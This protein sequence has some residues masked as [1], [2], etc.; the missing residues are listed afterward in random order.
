MCGRPA[1]LGSQFPSGEETEHIGSPGNKCHRLQVAVG[2]PFSWGPRVGADTQIFVPDAQIYVAN[3]QVLFYWALGTS[4]P[5]LYK[6][7]KIANNP[8]TC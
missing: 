8:E 5:V 2:W 6:Q 1:A 3:E 4:K 7:T